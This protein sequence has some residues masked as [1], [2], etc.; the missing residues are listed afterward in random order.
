MAALKWLPY[1]QLINSYV[2]LTIG[3]LLNVLLIYLV[4]KKSS[5][6]LKSYNRMLLW[7][8]AFDMYF[9]VMVFVSECTWLLSSQ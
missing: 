1:L 6:E 9:G 5:K 4:L 8:C 2:T 7:N 3:T